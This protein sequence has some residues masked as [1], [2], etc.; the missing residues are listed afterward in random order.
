VQRLQ[1]AILQNDPGL[2]APSVST[3]PGLS[4][5][6]RRV[7]VTVVFADLVDSTGLG[8]SLD[9]EA[10][11][12]VLRRY[13][14]AARTALERHGG[15]V[16]KF[17]G[18]AVV[19]VF[20]V[21]ERREDDAL[22][23]VRAAAELQEQTA[24]LNDELDHAH[25]V[26]VSIRI[27]VNT[28][29]AVTGDPEAGE[30]FATGH[31]VNVAAKLQQAAPGGAILVGAPTYAL[32]RDAVA[33][34]PAEP[35]RL[36]GA[37]A[38][39]PAFRI[40]SVTPGA[41]GVG[42][43]LDAPLVGRDGELD[44]LRRL[45]AEAAAGAC[46]L[47]TVVGD[48]GIGKTRL[49][50]ELTASVHGEARVLVGRCVSYGEGATWLP[51]AEIVSGLVPDAGESGIAAL[52]PGDP[53]ARVVARRIRQLLGL[54]QEAPPAA[55]GT[56]A[57][58]RMLEAL[59]RERP[60]VLVLDDIHWAE[61]TLLDLVEHVAAHARGARLLVVCL[62]RSDL[63][64]SRP[65]WPVQIR[66]APLG[67]GE[68]AQLV[69]ALPG[70][71]ELGEAEQTRIAEIAE[72]NPL[73]A[74]QLLAHVRED[75]AAEL[76][77]VPQSVEALI[78]SRLDR[79]PAGEL[80]LLERAA[81]VGREFSPA[82]LAVLADRDPGEELAALAAR[83]LLRASRGGA[84]RFHHV[85][86]R[87]VAYG[88]ITKERRSTLHRRVAEWLDAAGGADDAIV[89]YHLEQ[90]H[91]CRA[92][93]GS[94]DPELAAAAGA[95]L[96]R[97]GVEAWKRADAPA[98]V[99][100]L[101]RAAGLLPAAEPRAEVLCELSVA[102]GSVGENA[103]RRAALEQALEVAR[104]TGS[105][106]VEVRAN[107]ELAHAGVYGVGGL[108]AT[109]DELLVAASEAIPV[110]EEFGDD[111]GLGR[112]WLAVSESHSMRLDNR[113]AGEAASTAL[114]HYR[115]TGYSLSV[116]LTAQAAALFYGPVP[117][118]QALRRCDALL[119]DAA[120]D[121]YAR[122]NVTLFNAGLLAMRREF[123]EARRRIGDA[124]AIFEQL[125]SSFS[126]DGPL[127]SMRATIEQLAGDLRAAES[128]LRESRD[129]LERT[130]ET[131]F[132][133]TRSAELAYVLVDLGRFAEAE[134][135][136]E[137]ARAAST[138][139][140]LVTEAYW[141]GARA[142]LLGR[143]GAVDEATSLARAAVD[144]LADTDAL[145]QRART[146]L[147]LADVLGPRSDE[148]PLLVG[149]AVRLYRR[150]GN[151]VAAADTQSLLVERQPAG[152]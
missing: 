71:D 7:R 127:K 121:R 36:G 21:P 103:A 67:A 95:R 74:E 144:L 31:A 79:L 148:Y 131:A 140:D 58:C 8:A 23:A 15:T 93:L 100:L 28:G 27:G 42:R 16:E 52:L 85:L 24:A 98:A 60:L 37:A 38:P 64:D 6:E 133:A 105:R 61:P 45:F 126:V 123:A 14:R 122:A 34:E 54:D 50:N 102:L 136:A 70:A 46:R 18:D 107:V 13:Y 128:L 51:L 35:L 72:G 75:G 88:G 143:R 135:A 110:L 96:A 115:R 22:R 141:R 142:R 81:V 129:A 66:L 77:A 83:G 119:A 89:G 11:R 139:D 69:A 147:D 114:D 118:P 130:K 44:D 12:S 57:V 39:I 26:A 124:G 137:R 59:A 146:L 97:A 47:A 87:D 73:F 29:E 125:G 78:A 113:A 3:L 91:L 108:R 5:E 32:V 63:L 4:G 30:S 104:A 48:A 55:E 25:G 92:A 80:G 112:T 1:Q 76:D 106:R 56:W 134:D 53:E 132:A 10:Y 94:I 2:E 62:A 84:F 99:N 145:N 101:R 138:P 49:A 152:S 68:S 151:L 17:V 9:P 86:I 40:R 33:A 117:A 109:S 20:G 150:K 43:R 90:A 82:L 116:C 19:G 149:E 120:G 65:G 111:R 41:A